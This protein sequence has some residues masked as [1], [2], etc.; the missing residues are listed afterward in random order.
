MNENA[1]HPKPEKK[2]G[3]V[4]ARLRPC[5]RPRAEQLFRNSKD[6]GAMGGTSNRPKDRREESTSYKE[7]SL[8]DNHRLTNVALCSLSIPILLPRN[9]ALQQ[10]LRQVQASHNWWDSSC[11]TVVSMTTPSSPPTKYHVRTSLVP[12]NCYVLY[13]FDSWIWHI[14]NLRDDLPF[15][16]YVIIR[17]ASFI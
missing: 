2:G 14:F 12:L 3:M 15:G 16:T 4:V 8:M 17:L 13:P 5:P 9:G 10:C 11:C 7:T 1:N 6:M